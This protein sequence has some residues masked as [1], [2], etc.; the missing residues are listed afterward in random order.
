MRGK[1]LVSFTTWMVLTGTA[2]LAREQAARVIVDPAA[3]AASAR[4]FREL[5]GQ[6]GQ[7]LAG[8]PAVHQMGKA[9]LGEPLVVKMV[10]LDQLKRY[11]PGPG[12]DPAA[13]LEDLMT[14]VYPI[15]VDGAVLGEMVV[16]KVDGTWSARSFGGKGHARAM[17]KVRGQVM[18]AGVPADSTLLVRIPALNIEFVGHRDS[19][20]LQLTPLT[21]LPAAGLRAGQTL[22]AARAFELLLPLARQH[23]GLPT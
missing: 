6:A 8:M 15:R 10:G 1:I 21:D 4:A 7:R 9:A 16:G 11:Q 19:G 2:A 17:E 5:G 23:N 12:A 3:Q 14:V 18:A 22:P 13:L 20:G